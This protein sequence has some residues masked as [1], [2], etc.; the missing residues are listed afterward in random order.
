VSGNN[1]G[2]DEPVSEVAQVTGAK[3]GGGG[4][5]FFKVAAAISAVTVLMAAFAV[6]LALWSKTPQAPT[7]RSSGEALI[8]GDFMLTDQNGTAFTQDD[9]TGK[10]SLIYFGFTY[11]PDVC[12]A[13]LGKM[14]AALEGLGDRAEKVRPVFITVD[15]ERDDP[16]TIKKYLDFFHEDFVGLT[17]TP[18]QIRRAADAYKVYFKKVEE[19]DPNKAYLMDHTSIVYLMGP[20]GKFVDHYTHNSTPQ[21]MADSLKRHLRG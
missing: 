3:A 9:L 21:Q 1:G 6:G 13:E 17:G 5:P 10:F 20:D 11:C 4:F 18:E 8:G 14:T 12:P 7:V 2:R 15:P 19:E 16:E